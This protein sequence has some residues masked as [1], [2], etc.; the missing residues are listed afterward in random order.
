MIHSGLALCNAICQGRIESV[1][2]LLSAGVDVN[3]TTMIHGKANTPL[4]VAVH[5]GYA[6]IVRVLLESG[7]D[8][9]ASSSSN[10][11]TALHL[12][13]QGGH[14]TIVEMLLAAGALIDAQTL[15]FGATPLLYATF[16][17]HARIVSML[18]KSGADPN[19]LSKGAPSPLDW[20]VRYGYQEIARLLLSSAAHSHNL[21]KRTVARNDVAMT[22]L[23][24]QFGADA[25]AVDDA[26]F[27]SIEM[28][29]IIEQVMMIVDMILCLQNCTKAVVLLEQSAF[30][31]FLFGYMSAELAVNP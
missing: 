18:L 15:H 10:Q 9:N 6:D 1:R 3:C 22:R 26:D 25:S 5:H 30:V 11:E 29:S 16:R 17:G 7:A 13:A 27:S 8:A 31:N 28:R 2:D 24:L 19:F 20:A 12:A 14:E 4:R 23:L 21:L